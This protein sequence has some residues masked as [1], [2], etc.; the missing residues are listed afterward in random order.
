MNGENAEE[1]VREN[2]G[3]EATYTQKGEKRG[4][5]SKRNLFYTGHA[6]SALENAS[7]LNLIFK[8]IIF[9]HWVISLCVCEKSSAIEY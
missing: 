9:E 7:R 6:L 5:T 3:N 2:R 4:K 1:G 8:K